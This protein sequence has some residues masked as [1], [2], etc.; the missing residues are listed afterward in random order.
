MPPSLLA[1]QFAAL[2]EPKDAIVVDVRDAIP[3]QIAKI[4]AAL[5]RNRETA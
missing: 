1:S 4:R 3:A 5:K 2:E